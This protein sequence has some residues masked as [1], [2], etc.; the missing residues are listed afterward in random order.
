SRIMIESPHWRSMQA[1]G[2]QVATALPIGNPLLRPL[3]GRIDLRN[4]R[5]LLVIDNRITYCGSQNCADPEFLIKARFAPWVDALMRF[6]GPI[7]QQNQRLF[8]VDWMSATNENLDELLRQ[9]LHA[10]RP[11]FVA[12]AVGTGPTIRVSAM[13]ELFEALIYAARHELMI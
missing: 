5:K 3:R 13:P 7:A 8:A 9:P 11:G 12:Q 4:H 6:E 10:P 1:A 2:V